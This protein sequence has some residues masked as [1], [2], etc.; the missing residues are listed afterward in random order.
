M[1]V[2]SIF[3]YEWRHFS[4]SPFKYLALVLFVLA[5]IYGLH[6]ASNLYTK[7]Q[8]E[9]ERIQLKAKEA[10]D[11]ML[12][13]YNK[14]K[15]WPKSRAW[16]NIEKPFWAIWNAE[17]YRFKTPSPLL[18]YNV[19]Q[20]EQYGFYK[21]ANFLSSPYDADMVEEITNP[22]RLH[23]GLLDFSFVMLYLTPLLLLVF[24]YDIK[25][26]EIDQ[27]FINLIMI[28]N[29][30]NTVWL[31]SRILFYFFITWLITLLLMLYGALL[32]PVFEQSANGFWKVF[33]W[34][35]LYLLFWI[36]VY[37]I[38]LS[39]ST[40]SIGNTLKMTAFWLAFAFIIPGA[41]H[42]WVSTIHPVNLMTDFIDATR[43]ERDKLYELPDSTFQKK[44]SKLFPE[45]V[46][47][48]VMKDS[49]KAKKAKNESIYA[50]TNEITRNSLTTIEQ[51]HKDKNDIIASSYWYN[52]ITCFQNTLNRVTKTHF[53]DYQAYRDDIQHIIDYQIKLM[54]IDIWN[55]K[56]VDKNEYLNYIKLLDD[57]KNAL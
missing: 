31:W 53:D 30:N 11:K 3:V 21:E 9:I 38:I 10:Q 28:Q 12:A 15:E 35:N 32:A 5:A 13:Y 40:S 29:K 55:D 45:I 49:L 33:L 52:P 16:V 25:G 47:S 51:N 48:T 57:Y 56:T 17:I 50:L 36:I 1:K 37:G 4:R 24:L 27:G 54:V 19:G 20:A 14:E 2:N 26:A 6:N 23:T 43:D 22:E 34:F 46:N 8:S 7:Q 18:V 44:L 41:V 39:K 42:Q